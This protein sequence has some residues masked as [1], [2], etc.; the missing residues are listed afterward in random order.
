MVW[1]STASPGDEGAALQQLTQHENRV[2]CLGV[3]ERGQALCSGS[4]DTTLKVWAP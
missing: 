1:D 2:S 3:Q 4:W